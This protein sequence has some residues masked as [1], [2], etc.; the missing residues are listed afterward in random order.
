MD[1]A[2][3]P[4]DTWSCLPSSASS[5]VGRAYVAM[6]PEG[7]RFYSP[8]RS[9]AEARD[10]TPPCVRSSP[11]GARQPS[12]ARRPTSAS[13][14]R[15]AG[16][17]CRRPGTR[18]GTRCFTGGNSRFPDRRRWDGID[19]NQRDRRRQAGQE[20][21]CRHKN[22][23]K[24]DRLS[25]CYLVPLCLCGERIL[26]E[27][28][29]LENRTHRRVGLDQRACN[30]AAADVGFQAEVVCVLA[31]LIEDGALDDSVAGAGAAGGASVWPIVG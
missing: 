5:T 10:P 15:R 30:R 12:S 11:N 8:G 20:T 23:N 17:A 2:A 25:R 26:S 19:S 18:E 13:K 21:G 6:R 27:C 14:I 9:A 3:K 28:A 16:Y 24:S 4:A 7:A 31:V 29:E 22:T 1:F